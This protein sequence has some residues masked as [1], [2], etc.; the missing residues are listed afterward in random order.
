MDSQ[1]YRFTWQRIVIEAIYTPLKWSVIAHLEI[2]TISP[3]GAKL[4]IT[5]T[6]YLSHSQPS[7]MVEALGGDVEAQVVAWLDEEAGKPAWRSYVDAARQE[8]L[9]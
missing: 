2:R 6:G 7:G 5:D 9:F 8:E 3:A 4:P 1:V